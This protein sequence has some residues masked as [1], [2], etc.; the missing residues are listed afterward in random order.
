MSG[1]NFACQLTSDV[2]GLK[3]HGFG[4]RFLHKLRLV[5][6]LT[7]DGLKVFAREI[8]PSIF[9]HGVCF[10]ECKRHIYGSCSS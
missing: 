8:P 7:L 2:W 9:S 1:L 10:V 6:G 3:S 5:L 4:D